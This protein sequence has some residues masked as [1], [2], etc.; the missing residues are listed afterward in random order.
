MAQPD[1]SEQLIALMRQRILI[2]DGAMGTMIQRHKLG[3]SDYRGQRFADWPSDLK[4]NNDLLA[5]TQPQIIEGI[6]DAYLQAGADILETNT[7]NA[8][9]IAMAD[10]G[11]EDLSREINVAATRLARQVADRW[12]E[13]TPDKPRFVAAVLGPT[14]RTASLSPDVNDPGFRNISFSQLVDAYYESVD[15]VVEGGADLL[16][17][18]TIFD[19][20]NAKAALFAIDK[21]FEDHGLRLPIMISGT[22]TDQSGRTLSGQTTEAFYNSLRHARP[23]SIGLNCALGPDLL[24]Q[25]VEEMSRVSETH[26][27]AH[28]NAG[29]PNE[30]AEYDLGPEDMA[31]QIG[32]WAQSG[33]LNIVGGCCGTSP[34]HIAAIAKAVE[35]KAPRTL[36]SIQ[37]QCRLSGLEPCNIGPESLFVNV[38]ER[39]NV[40]GSAKF[41][42][43]VLEEKYEQA[44]DVCREQVENGA[45]I[46]DVNMD[47]G[48]LDGKAA[49]IRFLNLVASEPDISRVP[50]M[51]DSSK[52]EILEAG[53]QCSQGKPI[54]N[55]ISLKEGEEKFIEQ[56][57]L[58]R[59]YGAA[60]IVMAFDET[61]QA[62]SLARKVEICTRAYR[63]LTEQVGFPAEDIIFDPNIF[64]VATG[65]K[66][67]N[68]YGVDFIEATRRIKASLP[69]AL[70]SGGVSNVS[71]SFRGNNPVRE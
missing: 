13:K 67:H 70:V 68:N 51:I 24:R 18:E 37:P 30:F 59:R 52:W 61:G 32:E 65:I 19:T 69:H 16:L 60:V 33:F 63:T 6:H 46:V 64:A 3:E 29:L 56:A 40:T 71:F 1:R 47:E 22:I 15:G 9:R 8:T 28:P 53:L 48:M 57:Q 31:V 43:L 35:G 11:M 7:F 14:N 39:A 38:G 66:E 17:V 25:Y 2:L 23:L 41:K 58:C 62:D 44:L 55:S 50:L 45:Q 34:D 21:Y 49:M 36:P 5:I 26:V 4:G 42:R 27:S 20:L 10:Y 12:T 54:V